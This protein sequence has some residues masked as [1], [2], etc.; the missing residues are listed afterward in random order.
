MASSKA[1]VHEWRNYAL[2]FDVTTYSVSATEP[3][4][5]IILH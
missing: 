4:I 3:I 2:T 1:T 5:A